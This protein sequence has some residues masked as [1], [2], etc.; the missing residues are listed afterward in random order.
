MDAFELDHELMVVTVEEGALAAVIHGLGEMYEQAKLA[1]LLEEQLS[2]MEAKSGTA[3]EQV[4]DCL[5]G[6]KP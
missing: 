2:V 1:P 5:A 4:G 6:C 3:E